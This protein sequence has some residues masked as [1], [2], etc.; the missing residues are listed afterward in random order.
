[1]TVL[2]SLMPQFAEDWDGILKGFGLDP[3]NDATDDTPAGVGNR[4]G[5][6]V[7]AAREHDGMNQLG[8]EDGSLYNLRPYA[9]TYWLCAGQQ[10]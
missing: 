3:D 4:A 1:V 6:A 9:D 2:N 10:G 8:D 5:A 7:V